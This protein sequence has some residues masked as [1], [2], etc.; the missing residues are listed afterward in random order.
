MSL[1]DSSISDFIKQIDNTITEF[2]STISLMED[3]KLFGLQ[4]QLRYDC[5]V[6]ILHEGNPPWCPVCRQE[7]DVDDVIRVYR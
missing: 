2:S 3:K 5:T 4:C 1:T 7:F 6:T